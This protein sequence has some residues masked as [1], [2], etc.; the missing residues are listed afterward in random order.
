MPSKRTNKL[1]QLNSAQWFENVACK[2]TV[3]VGWDIRGPP[4]CKQETEDQKNSQRSRPQSC[5]ANFAG[6]GESD[7]PQ[8]PKA[9]RSLLFWTAP[10]PPPIARPPFHAQLTL[11]RLQFPSWNEAHAALRSLLAFPSNQRAPLCTYGLLPRCMRRG[12]CSQEGRP[13]P[14]VVTACLSPP[15]PLKNVY[16]SLSSGL[17]GGPQKAHVFFVSESTLPVQG[18]ALRCWQ[19]H[20]C[21]CVGF[22]HCAFFSPLGFGIS[23]VF[24]FYLSLPVPQRRPP[25]RMHLGWLALLLCALH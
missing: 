2:D 16:A 24:F 7:C 10:P 3:G 19:F 18:F 13:C 21:S 12:C 22:W 23:R 6:D 9:P 17:L 1:T 4:W 5:W 14:R 8:S 11:Y 20:P 15:S 25:Q